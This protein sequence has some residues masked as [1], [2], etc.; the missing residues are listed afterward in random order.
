MSQLN[1][2]QRVDLY[3]SLFRGREDVFAYRW[4]QAGTGK[5]G[6]APAFAD[7]G[8]DNYRPLTQQNIETH[9][10][11]HAALGIYPLLKNNRSWFIAADFDKCQSD[12]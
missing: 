12:A 1:R 3:R 7:R 8:K 9:L 11:G 2:Q 10:L 5:S 6:Y 4:E